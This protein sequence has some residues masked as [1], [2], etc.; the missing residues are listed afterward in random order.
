M[1]EKRTSRDAMRLPVP[2]QLALLTGQQLA[3]RQRS[4]Q[5]LLVPVCVSQTAALKHIRVS[6]KEGMGSTAKEHGTEHINNMCIVKTLML[7]ETQ[8]TT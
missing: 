8:V 5:K 3:S 1:A 4:Q 6:G 2:L 7:N